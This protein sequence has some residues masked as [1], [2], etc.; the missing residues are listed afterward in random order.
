MQINE[1]KSLRR[2]Q[3]TSEENGIDMDNVIEARGII[4]PTTG[5]VLTVGEAI[6][7]RVLDVRNG[8]ISTSIDGR[9]SVTIEEAVALNLIDVELARRLLGPCGVITE[10]NRMSL[11]EAIQRELFD[12]EKTEDRVKV[13]CVSTAGISVADAMRQGLLDPETGQFVTDNGEMMTIQEAYKRGFITK[14][15]TTVKIKRGALALADAISQGLVDDRL[16]QI[17]DRN[18]GECYLLDEA[19]QR[20]IVDPDVREI[21]DTRNDTKITI[22][23]AIDQGLINVK[24]GKYVHG[25]SM[26]KLSFKEARRRQLIVKPM[27][28]K[29]CCDLEIIDEKGKIFSPN[30]KRKLGILEAISAGVLDTD[31]I[32]SVSDTRSGDLLTLSDALASGI[33]K[34]DCG[35]YVDLK[36]REEL[37]IP[38]AVDRGLITSVA[39]KSIFDIDGFKDPISGEFISLNAALLKGLISPKSGGSFVVDLKTGRAVSFN[40]AVK[41]G[42]ARPEV[43]EMLNRGIG[44]TENGREISVLE[45]VLFELLDPR[46]GQLL[47]PR[48]KKPVPLEDAIKR[49]LITPDG[50]A[51][52]ASLL[53]IT[54]T[55]QTV[56]KTIKRYVTVTETGE[57]ITRDYKVSYRDAINRGLINEKTGEFTDPDTGRNFNVSEAI[58]QGLLSTPEARETERP[59]PKKTRDSPSKQMIFESTLY[60]KINEPTPTPPPRKKL[61]SPPR[62]IGTTTTIITHKLPQPDNNDSVSVINNNN[63]TIVSVGTVESSKESRTEYINDSSEILTSPLSPTKTNRSLN[64]HVST[65]FIK[66]NDDDPTKKSVSSKEQKNLRNLINEVE[67]FIEK[68]STSVEKKVFELPSDGWMLADAIEQKLFDPVAGLFIIPGTD[69]LVSFEECVKLEF[70]NPQSGV[71]VDPN[72]GRHVSLTRSLEKNILDSTGHYIHPRKITMKDAIAKG[73]IIL[74]YRAMEVD[75]TNPRLIQITKVTDKSD[76]VEATSVDNSS[77]DVKVSNSS[78]QTTSDPVQVSPGIIYDPE[79]ALVIFTESGKSSNILTAVNEGTLETEAIVVKDPET[80]NEISMARAVEKKIVDPKTGIYVDG[81]GRKISLS[82][83]AKFGLIAVVGT[84]LVA[85]AAAVEAVKKAMIKDPKTGEKIPREVAIERGLVTPDKVVSQ[86]ITTSVVVKDPTTGKDISA[87]EALK[88][89]IVT[90]DQFNKLVAEADPTVKVEISQ[91]TNE[92]TDQ[93]DDKGP[94][95]AEQTRF[96]VT[97]EPKYKVTIGTAKTV[98]QSPEREAKAIVLQKIRKKILTP[99]EAEES[100]LID[101]ETVEIL[102]A[103]ICENKDALIDAFKSNKIDR[104]SGKVTDPQRGDVISIRE[105]VERGII[106]PENG[107]ILVPLARSL[108]IPGLYNQGLLEREDGKIIHPETGQHLSLNEAII[109]EIVDPLS[110]ITSQDGNKLT[111]QSSIESDD[112]DADQSIVHTDSGDLNLVEATELNKFDRTEPTSPVSL[113]PVGMTFPV[114]LNRGLIDTAEQIITHPLTGKEFTVDEAIKND[115]IMS[116]PYPAAP[117]SIE[118]TKALEAGLIDKDKA[119]FNNPK[120]GHIIPINEA[121]ESGQ[122]VVESKPETESSTVTAVTETI[123]SYHTITTKTIQLLPGYSLVN[124]TQVQNIKTGEI[125]SIADAQKQGIVKDESEKRQEF[126]TRDIKMAFSDAVEQ[127]FVDMNAGTYTDPDTGAVM[128]IG[129][130][131]KNGILDTAQPEI[132]DS[133]KKIATSMTVLEAVD[134]I[135]DEKTEKF[136]DP[137]TNKSYNLTEAMEAGLIEADS[138]VY[139]VK[140]SAQITTKE[141]IERG[142]L[143]PKTGKVKNERGKSISVAEAAKLGLL[144]VVAAPVLAGKAVV[145]AVKNR[146]SVD[147]RP[148]MSPVPE[149]P[150]HQPHAVKDNKLKETIEKSKI[151]ENLVSESKESER[152]EVTPI[153]D[154]RPVQIT[155]EEAIDNDLIDPNTCKIVIGQRELPF[156]VKDALE[157][158]EIQLT[159]TVIVLNQTRIS[160]IEERPRFRIEIFRN[161]TPQYLQDQGVYDIE[162]EK[163]I[164]PYSGTTIAFNEFVLDLEIFDPDNVWVKDLSSKTNEYVPL[165]EAINRPLVDRNIGY[166]VDPKSGKKIQFCEAVQ[167]GMIIQR[168]SINQEES[169]SLTLQ[170]AIQ[171][172]ICDTMS[173]D[174]QDPRSGEQ[175]SLAGAVERGLIDVESVSIRNPVNDEIIPLAEA[176]ESGIVDLNRGVIIN[177]DTHSE[178]GIK[179]GFLKGLVLPGLR[180]PISLEAVITKGWYDPQSGNIEDPMSKQLINIDEAVGRGIIDAFI[181]ECQDTKAGSFLSLDDAL[182]VK[183]VNPKTGRLRDT[184]AGELLSLDVALDKKLIITTP[185]VPSLIDV[186]IQEY[187]SPKTGLVLNPMTGDESTMKHAL[188][189]GYVD[190]RMIKIKDDRNE[191]VVSLRDAEKSGLV[192]LE[193]GVLLYPHSMTLD[194]ALEKGYILNTTK[195]WT[196][197]EALA[198]QSYNPITGRFLMDGD[199]LPLEEA[200]TKGLISHDSPSVKDPRSGDVITLNDAIK[201]G[202]IDPKSGTALDPSTGTALSLTDAMDRGLVVPA[203]RKISL[204]EAVFKG[205]YDPK[206]GQFT[207]LETRERLPTD[208]AIKEGVIDPTSAIV[209]DQHGELITFS[210][211][212]KERIIDPKTG[213]VVT[214]KGQSMDFHEAFEQG[215]LLETRRPMSFSEAVFKGIL[216]SKTSLFLDPRTGTYLTITQAI[217]KHLIDADSVTVK[218]ANVEFSKKISLKEALKIGLLNGTTGKVKDSTRNNMEISLSE[219]YETGIIVDNKAAISVQRAIH[220]GLYDEKTGKIIDPST[221]RS[222]TLH[223]AMRMCVI[224]PKLVCYWDKRSETLLSLAETC[225]AGV[226]D[227]RTGMFKEPGANCSIPLSMALQLNLIVDI[228]STGF[229]LYEAVHMGMYDVPSGKFIH[230]LTNKKLTLS[231]AC[232]AEMINPIVSFVKNTKTNRYVLLPEA[233]AEGIIDDVRGTYTQAELNKVMNLLEAKK[234]GFIVPSSRPMSIEDAV[235]CGLYRADNGKFIDPSTNVFCDI[236]QAINSGLIDP[237][238]T[239]LKDTTS[240]Q[241]KSLQ[242]GISDDTIDV[243]RGQILDP[244]T[245]RTYTIDIALERGLLV[246]IDKP[247]TQQTERKNSLELLKAVAKDKIVKE[248]SIE[249]AIRYELLNP[250]KCFIKDPRTGKFVTLS[251]A[252]DDDIIDASKRGTIEPQNEK[253]TQRIIRFE[254][255]NVFIAEPISFDLAVEKELLNIETA[256]LTDPI[257]NEEITLKESVTRGIIDSDTVLIKDL[258]KKKLVTL[259]EAFRKGIMDGDKG[260]VLDTETSKLN[261]LSK[262][263]ESGLLT[264]QKRGLSFIETLQFGI[265]NPTTGAFNDPFTVTT[266]LDR[267]KLT[268]SQ[269]LESGLVDPSTTVIKDPVTG[270]ISSLPEAI[271]DGKIDPVAGK[272]RQNNSQ[273]SDLNFVQALDRGFILAAEARVSLM[274]YVNVTC[275]LIACRPGYGLLHLCFKIFLFIVYPYTM[276]LKGF[277][278]IFINLSI[279]QLFIY[280]FIMRSR[281]AWSRTHSTR[282][283]AFKLFIDNQYQNLYYI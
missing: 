145:D 270:E 30:H 209:R 37:T 34:V 252:L 149:S 241:I 35:R 131:I 233:I 133:P 278:L 231:E 199:R 271:S 235:K 129:Q 251:K 99:K 19:I 69:R 128:P 24:N 250:S 238:T 249:E 167:A 60:A 79:T 152:M 269:V 117:E 45:A 171:S 108:S 260:S 247:L 186:I 148:T 140:S 180:K 139:D 244:K 226:I 12:A 44:V 51:L 2:R 134:Q 36:T 40:E 71:V 198:H 179:E 215:I 61:S 122:L 280:Y 211:A 237:D 137:A 234:N 194:V 170:E 268:L 245:K 93:V 240:G 67:T 263:I 136:H 213:T 151:K 228:E 1:I 8:R 153:Q 221:G 248:C 114:A 166:M 96:R 257:T 73:L 49:G 232:Q 21:V 107:N 95:L 27:T 255:I 229:S 246:S 154:S 239:A 26:E 115:F 183:L 283:F 173:G 264:T 33:I 58:E 111:L 147:R 144:A 243:A 123:T 98:S 81:T 23:D 218:D 197:Q 10:K 185:F 92:F 112:I 62:A 205:F 236:V 254:E 80:G 193:K 74:E 272:F 164:D 100:G 262:A 87:D 189:I 206:T 177:L 230:P 279:N 155:L 3:R 77:E 200:I 222:I 220:Q 52:L 182:T 15:N 83:A 161:L 217:D 57:T 110:T 39:Q 159:E 29:D 190:S 41:L 14:I 75:S 20:G 202:L 203:K 102:E 195:P 50:A 192:D 224:S 150:A 5:Q 214:E 28:L 32:K 121:F 181:T 127:G 160:I 46:T 120:T 68:E 142:I 187:Y 59:S 89:G 165:R 54:V 9:T 158:G 225:R 91:P 66:S 276:T 103:T 109:C 253:M 277:L 267:K 212:I 162:S 169:L 227:R 143:D 18:T 172:G 70:I 135:Y 43:M 196:L 22:A 259:A 113:P 163:F 125:I 126:T 273:G 53:N 85:A 281:V 118:V 176:V 13:T 191:T 282:S 38:E 16:G 25:I 208:R 101:K 88:K 47:D 157:S 94:S 130:A 265:Y 188:A 184:K 76:R 104:N 219:A 116:L 78:E 175:L 275:L 7:L 4:H 90:S 124:P 97:T 72:N 106:D 65:V 11:L 261:T 256:K 274:V 242:Q 138:V 156:T 105:A 141:A 223:E 258:Q 146:K 86:P 31:N 216:D 55:T 42:H 6:S 204:P 64:D 56:T 17:V 210:R 82:D 119:V 174:L 178:I 84:P 48:S 63:S 207:S 201:L 168:P 132:T 266:L